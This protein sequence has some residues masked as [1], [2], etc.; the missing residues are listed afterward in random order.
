[1]MP[2]RPGVGRR[3]TSSANPWSVFVPA[4]DDQVL[5]AR[6]SHRR[7]LMGRPSTARRATDTGHRTLGITI[8][9]GTRDSGR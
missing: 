3:S 7:V 8:P 6:R 5:D 9:P 2:S 1:M 4:L